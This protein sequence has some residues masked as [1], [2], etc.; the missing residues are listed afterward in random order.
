MEHAVDEINDMN[1]VCLFGVGVAYVEGN[2]SDDKSFH[3]TRC[4][5]DDAPLSLCICA[6]TGHLML[7]PRILY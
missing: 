2:E 7:V 3:G 5:L 6:E 4:Q 1:G